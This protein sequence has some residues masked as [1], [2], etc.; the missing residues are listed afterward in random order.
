M[1]LFSHRWRLWGPWWIRWTSLR[2]CQG[3][4]GSIGNVGLCVQLPDAFSVISKEFNHTTLSASRPNV[5]LNANVRNAFSFASPLSADH[6]TPISHSHLRCVSL[7]KSKVCPW[8]GHRD[9]DEATDWDILCQPD[10]EN[11]NAMTDPPG[12][13]DAPPTT[14]PGSRSYLTFRDGDREPLRGEQRELK[15]RRNNVKI[16]KGFKVKGNQAERGLQ[17]DSF[18]TFNGPIGRSLATH[19]LPPSSVIRTNVS[20]TIDFNTVTPTPHQET[21]PFASPTHRPDQN[22]PAGPDVVADIKFK[23]DTPFPKNTQIAQFQHLIICLS[24]TYN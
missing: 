8:A 6:I 9:S 7:F 21:W 3:Q 22:K 10:G 4:T 12:Q 2:C 11:I 17:T 23:M 1:N 15:G 5:L 19:I 14:S 24:A 20:L 18:N 16:I 13:C